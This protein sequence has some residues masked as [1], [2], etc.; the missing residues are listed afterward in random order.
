MRVLIVEDEA[1]IAMP[2]LPEPPGWENGHGT[3]A[4]A[5][6]GISFPILNEYS[7]DRDFGRVT[8]PEIAA[9]HSVL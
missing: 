5:R 8:L 3:S 6:A 1:I 4:L 9:V 7:P 2:L